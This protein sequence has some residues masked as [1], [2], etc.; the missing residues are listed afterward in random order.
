MFLKKD[1]FQDFA[2]QELLSLLS[3]YKIPTKDLFKYEEKIQEEDYIDLKCNRFQNYPYVLINIDLKYRLE[4]KEILKRAVSIGRFVE[5]LAE[6]KN[7]LELTKQIFENKNKIEKEVT[8][9]KTYGF[10][11]VA[12]LNTISKKEQMKKIED[13]KIAQ[14]HAKCNLKS[15]ERVFIIAENF[16]KDLKLKNK[17]FGKDIGNIIKRKCY[18]HEYRLTN[19]AFLGPTS[20]DE[21]LA[22]LMNNQGLVKKSNFV[23]DPFSGTGSLLIS[24]SHFG[25]I[26]FGGEI[27]MRVLKGWAVGNLNKKSTFVKDIKGKRVDAFLNY[28]LY[29]LQRPELFRMDSV[30]TK[31]RV[32]GF[33]D[34]IICDPPY[35][36]RAS[37]R[38]KGNKISTD[39]K[40][41]GKD[42]KNSKQ[43][44]IKNGEKI[45]KDD[46]E[47]KLE[48]KEKSSCYKITKKLFNLGE[49]VL[50]KG[51]R[52]VFLYPTKAENKIDRTFFK[53]EKNF[54]LIA[55]SE[56]V[57][58]KNFSRF[59]LTFEKLN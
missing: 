40:R 10:R 24:A 11:I 38:T 52:L 12:H 26:C 3:M 55:M 59:L 21:N 9:K 30:G 8:S 17:Y 1:P 44:N 58:S 33:F 45:E 37:I 25:G 47:L 23:L 53:D 7:D 32:K 29:G 35:G 49:N 50:K 20:T 22:F 36:I 2:I 27:D 28:D 13:L 19:R 5:I 34:S 16:T 42:S 18:I 41:K 14:F 39:K 51:G 31:F 54:K 4:L 6:G 48:E 46:E 43:E 56:N 15:P 57:L